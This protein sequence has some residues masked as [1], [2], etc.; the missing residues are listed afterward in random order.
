MNE[1]D[2][3][4]QS[5]ALAA[6]LY[7]SK[8]AVVASV[9]VPMLSQGVNTFQIPDWAILSNRGLDITDV[10]INFGEGNPTQTLVPSS[11]T[12]QATLRSTYS[13][14]SSLSVRCSR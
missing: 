13:E 5:E 3:Q 11:S 14:L 8:Q 4:S 6:L 2:A 7:T 10:V 9:L 12:V 1:K